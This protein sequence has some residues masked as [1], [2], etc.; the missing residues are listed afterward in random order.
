MKFED[1]CKKVGMTDE[2]FGYGYGIAF[3]F[4]Q[5]ALQQV[6]KD[7][8]RYQYLR[9][10]SSEDLDVILSF[11]TGTALLPVREDLDK[12]IDYRMKQTEDKE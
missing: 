10:A 5:K 2:Q 12:A 3:M 9:E 1:Y 6:D 4:W 7:A 8:L 11:T